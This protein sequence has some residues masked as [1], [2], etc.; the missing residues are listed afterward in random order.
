MVESKSGNMFKAP[1]A[2]FW[3]TY[4]NSASDF[5]FHW[6]CIEIFISLGIETNHVKKK[7]NKANFVGSVV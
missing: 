5:Y 1:E 2:Y 6:E 4:Q 3:I 7:N